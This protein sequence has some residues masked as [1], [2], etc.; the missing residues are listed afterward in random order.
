MQTSQFRSLTNSRLSNSGVKKRQFTTRL[1]FFRKNLQISRVFFL[2]L[3]ATSKNSWT[4]SSCQT[5]QLT[6]FG[7]RITSAVQVKPVCPDRAAAT[8]PCSAPALGTSSQARAAWKTSARFPAPESAPPV[9]P[10]AKAYMP[11]KLRDILDLAQSLRTQAA[12]QRQLRGRLP[13]CLPTR[14]RSPGPQ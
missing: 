8:S 9:L 11:N 1:G 12:A 2:S 10:T 6:L 7:L 4:D 13:S 14:T 5:Y 3:L